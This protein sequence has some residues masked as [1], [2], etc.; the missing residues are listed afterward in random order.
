MNPTVTL[1]R[2][3]HLDYGTLGQLRI[4]DFACWT[5]ELPWRDN[6]PNVSCIPEGTYEVAPDLEG[7]WTGYPEL[8]DVPGRT[9]IIIHPANE[10]GEIQGCI[11]PGMTR[12]LTDSAVRV[13]Q[14]RLAY[15]ALVHRAGKRFTLEVRTRRAVLST[16]AVSSAGQEGR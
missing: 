4:G 8:Q 14:S 12:F 13:G 6:E 5:L 3:A 1:E 2:I 16:P 7:R 15:N 11:A 9:E 10:V